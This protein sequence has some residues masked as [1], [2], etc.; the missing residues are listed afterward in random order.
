MIFQDNPIFGMVLA[1]V[2]QM[3]RSVVP[4]ETFTT[5]FSARPLLAASLGE[6]RTEALRKAIHFLIALSPGMAH[7][8]R[9]LTLVLLAAGTLFYAGMEGLRLKGINVPLVS[10]ITRMAARDRDGG[11][12]VLGPVTLGLGAIIALLFYRHPV[13]TNAIYAL[14]FG[15]G[16][17]SLIG[18]VFG[19]IRPRFMMG[20]SIEGSTACFIGVLLS[21]YLVSHNFRLSL[22]TALAATLTEALPLEDYDNIALPLAAGFVAN[23]LLK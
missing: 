4:T 13:S 7:F 12:F 18:K 3:N 2:L 1:S 21:A 8:N 9:S 16:F 10:R 14:A 20:K 5:S 23:M 19:A 22:I 11:R 17:A 15:D 6:I